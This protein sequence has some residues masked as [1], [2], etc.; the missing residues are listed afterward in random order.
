MLLTLVQK[1]SKAEGGAHAA[2]PRVR[3]VNH[4]LVKSMLCLFTAV[5]SRL[6]VP[7]F[8][9]IKHAHIIHTTY[10]VCLSIYTCSS[11]VESAVESK[12][13]SICFLA[14]P[15]SGE[16]PRLH[17]VS[18]YTDVAVQLNRTPTEGKTIEPI[19]F[20]MWRWSY[21]ILLF[22]V[23]NQ[24]PLMTLSEYSSGRTA[25]GSKQNQRRHIIRAVLSDIDG[26]LVHYPDDVEDEGL[27]RLPP[28]STGMK[29]VISQTTINLCQ[30]I[31]HTKVELEE[32]NGVDKRHVILVLVSGMR[33]KTL[34]QRLSSLP[35]AD[36]YCSEN[37]GRIFYP[38]PLQT[39]DENHA[40]QHGDYDQNG[41][42]IF[43]PAPTTL[44]EVE[45]KSARF[46]RLVEDMDWRMRHNSDISST[47]NPTGDPEKQTSQTSP[48]LFE[49]A[50]KLKSLGWVLDEKGY[51]TCFRIHQ[52]H[53]ITP[54][55][56]VLD[57]NSLLPDGLMI[58]TNL[59]CV[60]VYPQT[61]G[62][63]NA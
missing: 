47:N 57:L 18:S 30:R 26:T 48:L 24:A 55:F 38:E 20:D 53:Q 42:Y 37:G 32:C 11:S 17:F 61:S 40:L 44:R 56:N 14:P 23:V 25:L 49:F 54:L 6:Y 16:E 45:D 4:H 34:L 31:R 8:A 10:P 21:L 29:G 19:H 35:L 7:Y 52:K 43:R 62:K 41:C 50:S 27:I 46:Y 63:K 2:L 3:S 13:Y 58:S 39:L 22:L 9:A 51:T 1:F 33:T 59:G 12:L 60:D 28:S 5:R 36:A 15:T